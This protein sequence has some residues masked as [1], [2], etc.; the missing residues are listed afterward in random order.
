MISIFILMF[1]DIDDEDRRLLEKS[2]LADHE[3]VL[4]YND[5][6]TYDDVR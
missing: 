2:Q 4:D 5:F 1:S 3:R 6:N